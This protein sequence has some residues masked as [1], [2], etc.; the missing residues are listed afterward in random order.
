MLRIARKKTTVLIELAKKILSIP[1]Y[2]TW[3]ISGAEIVTLV[4]N[5]ILSMI[6]TPLLTTLA[7]ILSLSLSE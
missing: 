3:S 5:P 2:S 1:I 6:S 7:S 4:S